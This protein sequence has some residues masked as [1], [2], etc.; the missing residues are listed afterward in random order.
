MYALGAKQIMKAVGNDTV[1]MTKQNVQTMY[2]TPLIKQGQEQTIQVKT[3]R[4]KLLYL[5][6]FTNFVLFYL[7]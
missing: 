6:H 5:E 2:V 3:V 1:F 4:N 7:N